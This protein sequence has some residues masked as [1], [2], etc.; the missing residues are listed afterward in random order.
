MSSLPPVA[1]TAPQLYCQLAP[2]GLRESDLVRI[3]EA[4]LLG[5]R[6]TAGLLRG[7]GKP[8]ACHLVGVASLVAESRTDD[9]DAI[10][11]AL[12]HAM[13]QDRVCFG[14]DR[15]ARRSRL[16]TVAGA[17][18]EALVARYDEAGPVQAAL[19]PDAVEDPAARLVRIMQLADELDDAIDGGPWWHGSADDGPE[20]RGGAAQRVAGFL[21]RAPCYAQAPALGAPRLLDRWRAIR[22][23]W[24]AGL[25]P[26]AFR[27]GER[28]TFA[29]ASG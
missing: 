2:L 29:V 21:A 8:F 14:A 4:C 28:S 18:V 1:Q 9:A 15:K 24:A 11:A 7:S 10:V 19:P 27:S 13:Y 3:R 20:V 5:A 16:L 25:W 26:V 23:S 12:L 6:A 22:D 17:S